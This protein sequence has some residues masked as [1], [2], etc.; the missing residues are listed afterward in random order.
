MSAESQSKTGKA[1]LA[2]KE[3]RRRLVRGDGDGLVLYKRV[4]SRDIVPAYE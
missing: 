4:L 1:H 3:W 2:S